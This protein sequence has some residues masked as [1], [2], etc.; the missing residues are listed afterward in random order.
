MCI[1]VFAVVRKSGK[2]LVGVSKRSSRWATEWLSSISKYTGKDLEEEWSATRLPATY[3][4]EG[5][6]PDDALRRVMRDQLGVNKFSSS[7]PRVFSYTAPSDWYPGNKH[8]DLAFAYEV[9]TAQ[10]PRDHPHW[11]ELLFL[12]KG[13]LRKRNFGWNKDFIRDLGLI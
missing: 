10:N 8:W 4:F 2:V 13:E 5:E 9:T 7:G 6:H 3:I 1:S 11:K 12:G